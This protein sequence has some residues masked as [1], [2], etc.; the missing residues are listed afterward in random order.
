MKKLKSIFGV[1]LITQLL[2]SCG[3]STTVDSVPKTKEVA[4]DFVKNIEVSSDK[5]TLNMK[6]EYG[7]DRLVANIEF[8][9]ISSCPGCTYDYVNLTL[10]DE[11]NMS[12]GVIKFNRSEGDQ[13][14]KFDKLIQNG[15][16]KTTFMFTGGTITNQMDK[17]A[18]KKIIESCKSFSIEAK[19]LKIPT[20]G[21]LLIGKEKLGGMIVSADEKG[22]HGL[23]ISLQDLS[24]ESDWS[25]AKKICDSYSAGNNSEWRLPTKSEMELIY[26]NVSGDK[27]EHKLE[28]TYYWTGTVY[29]QN[30]GT[31]WPYSFD[32]SR[33]VSDHNKGMVNK[34][35]VRA[36]RE[37]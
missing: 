9:G 30:F 2:T 24:T 32:C 22:E 19:A 4:G 14:D 26:K 29:N 33:G 27:M 1:I 37:F 3:D 20:A 12:L 31:T 25:S 17:E 28:S 35:H 8:K 21:E 34:F 36:V 7:S 10:L 13:I 11:K 23:L 15:S 18:M 6:K 16:G 5:I